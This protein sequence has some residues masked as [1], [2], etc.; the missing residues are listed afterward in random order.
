M[1]PVKLDPTVL[2]AQIQS[3]QLLSRGLDVPDYIQGVLVNSTKT[4]PKT[5]P[6]PPAF[7]QTAID[8]GNFDSRKERADI[9][10]LGGYKLGQSVTGP[11]EQIISN[12]ISARITELERLP[13]NI[14]TL[15][16]HNV[17]LDPAYKIP[18]NED[19]FKIRAIL[20][21]KSLLLLTKQKSLRQ[22][23]VFNLASKS[24]TLSESMNMRYS[25]RRVKVRSVHE[26]RLTEQLEAQQR[27]ERDR[28]ERQKHVNYVNSISL[29]GNQ[30][31]TDFQN[32]KLKRQTI[33]SSI[34]S[35]H[36]TIEKEEQKRAERTAKQR[37]QALRDHDEEAY[38][39]LLDQTKDTRITHLLRQTNTFLDSLTRA[40]K[41]QQADVALP[42]DIEEEDKE[43]IDYYDQSHRIKEEITEQAT[44]MVGGT[45]K[46]YQIK[47]L[48]W[49][50]SLYNNKLN[51]ILAD[52][53]GLG[54]TIQSISLITY[55]IET[56]RQP[57]P[58]LVIVPLSTLTN[59]NSEFEKWAPSVKRVV[60]KGPPNARRAHQ[61]RIRTGDFQVLLTTFEY[62]IKDRPVLGKIKWVHMIIDEGHRMKN[63]QSKLSHTLTTYYTSQYRLIL[64][65][66]P[67]QNNLPELWALLNFVLP[68]IFNSVKTFDEWFNTP[69]ANTG[70]QD[71]IELNEEES[72]LVIRRL[73]KVLRP[74]L[75]RRLKK[76]VEKDLPDK[77]E[78]VLKCKMSGLQSKLYGHML[79]YNLLFVGES[80]KTGLRGLNNKIMQL[81]KICNHP[82]VFEEVESLVNPSKITNDNLWR[83][84]GKFELLDRVLP[85]LKRTDH[86]VLMF[87]QM[88]QVMDIMEDYLRYRGLRYLRLDGSVKADDRS[89]LLRL[90]NAP[91]SPYFCFLLSTR[92]GGLGLNLQTADTVIIYDSDWNPHQ[93]LQAQDRAHR[94]GQTKEVRILRLITEDSVEE[95]I[96][97][98]AH[99]KLEIDG[100]VIQAGKFDNKSTSEEQEAFLR[101]LIEAEDAKRNSKE[102]EEDID[103]EELNEILARSEEETVIFQQMD[104][105][106]YATSPYG[107]DKPFD[108]LMSE[109]ELPEDYKKDIEVQLE[110]PKD[111]ILGRGARDRKKIY[112]DDGLTDEQWLDAVDKDVDTLE[113][114]IAKK[115]LRDEK[116]LEKRLSKESENQNE[117]HNEEAAIEAPVENEVE[118]ESSGENANLNVSTV[119]L[120]V[121]PE[122]PPQ[123]VETR[124]RRRESRNS[125]SVGAAEGVEEGHQE[126]PTKKL[127]SSGKGLTIKLTSASASAS[128]SASA[129]ASAS[130]SAPPTKQQI[131]EAGLDLIKQL[132]S[133][134]SP[135]ETEPGAEPRLRSELFETLPS[136][137]LYPAYFHII[138]KPVAIDTIQKRIIRGTT[139][140]S[141]EAIRDDVYLMCENAFTYNEAG[142]EVYRDAEALKVVTEGWYESV[143]AKKVDGG[144]GGTP[145]RSLPRVKIILKK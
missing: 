112:Y 31:N 36:S 13:A 131:K 87:F 109:S 83:V 4:S 123:K 114:A 24:D 52:E 57:G 56:K 72:L 18:D 51:G 134:S 45:L 64:T 17:D 47:G 93:D 128:P 96:L 94:I 142:S 3:F 118:V 58:Y 91:D 75:L 98:R 19:E 89:E 86:R 14:G 143:N 5:T 21:L 92:A 28:K 69:F 100:K 55:L 132:Q 74:F 61:A 32:K 62:I 110:P 99:A 73:H 80:S 90:F 141:Y 116:R 95:V 23:I 38:I 108:R 136:R 119:V 8:F 48:Q 107:R 140:K 121:E 50:V 63:T 67:L 53:M 29:H 22:K 15:D 126:R 106:R 129:S 68:K 137:K 30:V 9:P 70:G 84:A 35:A 82:F 59:W 133:C 79:K 66:T 111:E 85:K 117:I 12:R 34:L 127:A 20:E 101:S 76:E 120:K 103:D 40:V 104:A 97:S 105:D 54:K 122:I 125:A 6:N 71:K 46:S 11:C 138:S 139:Y 115:R 7:H 41:V 44:I 65:G 27:N 88:T 43:K 49:M 26:L 60:Y 37:L 81:R 145:K 16:L 130:V 2:Q 77:V 39:K 42:D 10:P 33:G 102:E 124:K 1:R 135:A 144:G 113:D 25:H 78:K